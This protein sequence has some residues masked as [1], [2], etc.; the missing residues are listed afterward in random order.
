MA[1]LPKKLHFGRAYKCV[2]LPDLDDFV[3]QHASRTHVTKRTVNE[4]HTV[5]NIICVKCRKSNAKQILF[6]KIRSSSK[7]DNGGVAM[8]WRTHFINRVSGRK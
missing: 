5:P 2:R 8:R 6:G 3:F 7:K 1:F 4:P